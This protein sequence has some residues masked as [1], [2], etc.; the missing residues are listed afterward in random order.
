MSLQ[1]KLKAG[2][3]EIK[4]GMSLFDIVRLLRNGRQT[5]VNLV[6][7]KLRTKEGPGR[8]LLVSA[9]SVIRCR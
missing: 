2:R 3:Y 6:I 1:E 8:F 7:T 9:L 5:P 4:K